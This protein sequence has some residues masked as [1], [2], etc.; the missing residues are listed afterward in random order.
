MAVKHPQGVGRIVGAVDGHI[1]RSHGLRLRVNNPAT[2]SSNRVVRAG[3]FDVAI[4]GTGT[5]VAQA[6]V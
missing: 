5:G 6:E 2:M 4:D 1:A 3:I